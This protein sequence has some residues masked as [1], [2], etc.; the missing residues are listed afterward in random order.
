VEVGEFNEAF[1][2]I[3]TGIQEGERVCLRTPAAEEGQGA[4]GQKKASSTKE[5]SASQSKPA[6][7]A[8]PSK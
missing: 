8:A 3:K 4:E 6:S 1:I 2:E 7:T 5:S